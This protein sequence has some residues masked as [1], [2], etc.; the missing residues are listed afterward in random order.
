MDILGARRQDSD[1]AELGSDESPGGR[2]P[3]NVDTENYEPSPFRYPSP[4][5]SPPAM[6]STSPVAT[7]GASAGILA[8]SEKATQGSHATRPPAPALTNSARPSMESA[9]TV[10]TGNTTPHP[11]SSAA[12]PTTA[13]T[14]ADDTSRSDAATLGH[15]A[16]A[17]HSSIR[18]APSQPQIV[19]PSPARAAPPLGT[20][21]ARPLPDPPRQAETRFVQHEDAGEVV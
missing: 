5:Q 3:V 16:A 7:I 17:R 4:T 18:K 12:A 20:E 8:A 1:D 2:Q 13:M 21:L 9:N 10:N 14:V 15:S 19:P 11:T 6:S